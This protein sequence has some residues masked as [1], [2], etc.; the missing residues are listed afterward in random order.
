MRTAALALAAVLLTTSPASATPIGPLDEADQAAVEALALYDEATARH[1]LQAVTEADVLTDLVYQQERSRER[2]QQLLSPYPRDLQEQL[3]EITRYPELIAR[4]VEGGSKSSDELEAIAAPYPEEAR[5]AALA[6]GS[7]H[8]KVVARIDALLRDEASWLE[9]RI[10]HLPEAKRQAF[11]ALVATPELMALLAENTALAVLLGDAYE[12]EPEVV[13]AWLADLRRQAQEESAEQAR[14]FARGVEDDPELAV[15]IEA[16]TSSYQLETGYSAYQPTFVHQTIVQ[17]RPYSWWV[18]YPW[19]YE[20]SFGYYEPW[21]YWY[22]RPYWAFGGFR[23]GP[24]LL[25]SFGLPHGGFWGWYFHRPIHHTYYP[26]VTHHVV[27][28]Y[29]RYYVYPQHGYSRQRHRVRPHYPAAQAVT[30]FRRDAERS[31]PRGFLQD[32]P[33]RV[34]RFREYGRLRSDREPERRAERKDAGEGFRP[35]ETLTRVKAEE[36]RYQR[37][38]RIA[39]AEP[40]ARPSSPQP[41]VEAKRRTAPQGAAVELRPRQQ[42]RPAPRAPEPRQIQP[43]RAQRVQKQRVQSNARQARKERPGAVE[44]FDAKGTGSRRRAR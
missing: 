9:A 21:Y 40:L 39:R 12:R 38:A 44:R 20:V 28:H 26:R 1:A 22:P 19:W 2:F 43:E 32:H 29:D 11:R 41:R 35:A 37:E 14:E 15:E 33:T 23:F 8:W 7:S 42:A 4:I 31:M 24:R 36:R 18:G 16:A 27:R 34:D 5:A 17:L 6:A 3:F 13:I 30:H 10:A 25:V